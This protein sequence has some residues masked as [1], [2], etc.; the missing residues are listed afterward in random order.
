V[1]IHLAGQYPKKAP[2]RQCDQWVDL[3]HCAN[4]HVE[5]AAATVNPHLNIK[6]SNT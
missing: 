1:K 2:S 4:K 6:Q 5:Q 3:E